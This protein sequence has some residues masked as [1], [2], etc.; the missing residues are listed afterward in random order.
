[1]KKTAFFGYLPFVSETVIENK[2]E[3]IIFDFITF[4][5]EKVIFE[6]NDSDSKTIWRKLTKEEAYLK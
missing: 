5:N 3:T 4:N 2:F 1:L 6:I